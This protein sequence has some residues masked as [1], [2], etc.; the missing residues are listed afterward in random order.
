[1]NRCYLYGLAAARAPIFGR[2]LRPAT[3]TSTRRLL[4]VDLMCNLYSITT[5][6]AAIIVLFR[7]MNRYVGNLPPMPGVF[8]G[9]AWTRNAHDPCA[10]RHFSER[11]ALTCGVDDGALDGDVPVAF[12][13]RHR[14]P[15]HC[16]AKWPRVRQPSSYRRRCCRRSAQRRRSSIEQ[17]QQPRQS[18]SA[19]WLFPQNSFVAQ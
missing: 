10:P 3:R 18:F 16:L 1:M 19:S 2:T 4:K 14:H 5:N 7:V 6:Q 9:R 15:W 8:S 17:R 11:G 13:C 12:A